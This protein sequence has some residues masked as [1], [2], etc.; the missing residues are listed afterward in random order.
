MSLIAITLL[1][2]TGRSENAIII[3][4]YRYNPLYKIYIISVR[5]CNKT[6]NEKV[7]KNKTLISILI[8]GVFLLACH[9][10]Y[11]LKRFHSTNT[12]DQTNNSDCKN[13]IID[14]LQYNLAVVN[15]Y[16]IDTA[17]FE[18]DSLKLV[19]NYCGG[20]G[21][22]DFD[23]I[24][25]GSFMESYPVQLNIVLHIDDNDPCEALI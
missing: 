24:T 11:Y 12:N 20:C 16:Y 6:L 10:D 8:G 1:F 23:L 25:D 2:K 13:I 7:M 18:E 9:K 4:F 5:K 19:V 15:D 3:I 14:E 21:T 17:Y 22:V